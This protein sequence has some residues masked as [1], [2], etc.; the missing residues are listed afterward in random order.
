M[1]KKER[2]QIRGLP[3][4][5]VAVSLD[6]VALAAVNAMV[7]RDDVSFSRAISALV[8]AAAVTDPTLM[9]AIRK[10]LQDVVLEKMS[11]TGWHPGLAEELA[12][13]VVNNE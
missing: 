6:V 7:E 4:K 2:R 5:V 13:E 12:K 10:A 3:A 8:T 1:A 11:K 9:A